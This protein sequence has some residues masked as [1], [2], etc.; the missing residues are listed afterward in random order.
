MVI[1]QFSDRLH[2][3][4]LPPTAVFD[5]EGKRLGSRSRVRVTRQP[6]LRSPRMGC[7]RE[8]TCG[9]EGKGAGQGQPVVAALGRAN[10]F[11]KEVPITWKMENIIQPVL[12]SFP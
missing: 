1:D 5:S 7:G 6:G 12:S 8:D 9:R 2:K 10:F 11:L 3:P 4:S